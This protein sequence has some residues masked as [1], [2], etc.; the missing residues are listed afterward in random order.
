MDS[1]CA[2][3]LTDSAKPYAPSEAQKKGIQKHQ[4][5]LSLD[6]DKWE[7]IIKEFDITDSIIPDRD[8]QEETAGTWY[9]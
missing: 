9:G 1:P 7:E 3:H 5:V 8:E 6:Y 2:N 4:A